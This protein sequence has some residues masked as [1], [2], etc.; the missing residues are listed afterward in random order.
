MGMNTKIVL[1]FVTILVIDD[2]NKRI[3]NVST[4]TFKSWFVDQN[5]SSMIES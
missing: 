1:S 4:M 2:N 5:E 3:L